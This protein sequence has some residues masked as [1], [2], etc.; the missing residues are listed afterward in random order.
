MFFFW[1]FQFR[2]NHVFF[3]ELFFI[4]PALCVFVVLLEDWT[5]A[6]GIQTSALRLS[7]LGVHWRFL[8]EVQEHT[9]TQTFLGT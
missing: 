6:S 4:L 3:W 5:L 1:K 9:G 2:S 7:T 8:I